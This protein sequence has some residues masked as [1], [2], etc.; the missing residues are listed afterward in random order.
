MFSLFWV[1]F[2]LFFTS[3]VFVI[4]VLITESLPLSSLPLSLIQPE[5]VIKRVSSLSLNFNIFNP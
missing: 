4:S 5:D 3:E 2:V 1:G